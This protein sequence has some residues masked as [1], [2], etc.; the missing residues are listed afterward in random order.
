MTEAG[1]GSSST[2][3]NLWLNDHGTTRDSQTSWLTRS[4]ACQSRTRT[5]TVLA[6]GEPDDRVTVMSGSAG[7]RAEQDPPRQAPRRVADPTSWLPGYRRLSPRYERRSR[8]YLAFLGL[9]RPHL[10]QAPLP[11][12]HIGHGLTR[13][14]RGGEKQNRFSSSVPRSSTVSTGTAQHVRGRPE[15]SE[16]SQMP[17]KRLARSGRSFTAYL[18]CWQVRYTLANMASRTDPDSPRDRR[19]FNEVIHSPIRLQVC[20]ILAATDS[21]K[22]VEVQAELGITDS[23]LSKNVRVLADAGFVDQSKHAEYTGDRQRMVTVLTLTRQGRNAY[24]QH[25]AWLEQITHGR[26]LS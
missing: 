23:H 16:I 18:P 15:A 5:C 7:G 22:F 11:T 12:H 4:A 14:G 8:N 19:A 2:S 1:R 20:A 21:L 26:T 17:A 25:A 10:L 3:T 24:R 13:L 9:R 6:T